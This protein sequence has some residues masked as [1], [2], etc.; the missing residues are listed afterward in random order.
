MRQLFQSVKAYVV[1]MVLLG[2]VYP[3]GITIVAQALMPYNANGSLIEKN[4]KVVGSVLIAQGFSRPEYFQSRLSANAYDATNSGGTNLGPSSKKLI[5]GTEAVVKQIRE[6]NGL[7]P[8]A[9]VPA[10]MA[11]TSASGLDPH[12][13]YENALIQSKRV[14]QLRGISVR[15]V[16]KLVDKNTDCDFLGLWGCSGVNVLKLNIALDEYKK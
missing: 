12:I 2:L 6:A 4:N 14:A 11:L 10:D 8:S 5:D 13:S 7:A 3:L 16:K 9:K 15:E 1:F